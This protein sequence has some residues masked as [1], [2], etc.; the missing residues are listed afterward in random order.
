MRLFHKFTVYSSC[1][2]NTL[3]TKNT[4]KNFIIFAVDIYNKHLL[5]FF[6]NCTD[7]ISSIKLNLLSIQLNYLFIK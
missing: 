7:Q 5:K 1:I 6:I 3:S 4:E 2:V